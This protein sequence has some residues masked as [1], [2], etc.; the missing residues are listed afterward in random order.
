[1]GLTYL[2][3]AY[4]IFNPYTPKERKG[5]L[6]NGKQNENYSYHK[7]SLFTPNRH[8]R[9][10]DATT[11]SEIKKKNLSFLGLENKAFTRASI[12]ERQKTCLI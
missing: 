8:E 5:N 2:T 3:L 11:I 12:I 1:M 7:G 6:L 9:S 4:L 10:R